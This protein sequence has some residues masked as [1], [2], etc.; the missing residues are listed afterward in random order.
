MLLGEVTLIAF[1]YA[2]VRFASAFILT[3]FLCL[4]PQQFLLTGLAISMKGF[5]NEG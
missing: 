1:P 2:P 3:S 5:K 4:F